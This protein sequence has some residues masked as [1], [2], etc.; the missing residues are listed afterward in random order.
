[1]GQR[2]CGKKR[3]RRTV[4]RRVEVRKDE[5]NEKELWA[6]KG[7]SEKDEKAGERRREERWIPKWPSKSKDKI[8]L[9]ARRTHSNGSR[10]AL[11]SYFANLAI[12][13]YRLP[14]FSFM[15]PSRASSD[16]ERFVSEDLRVSHFLFYLTF[17]FL[18]LLLCSSFLSILWTFFAFNNLVTYFTKI[19]HR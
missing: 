10:L 8:S 9:R 4:R 3:R 19:N 18:H 13:L 6:K 1:M 11:V 12:K 14:L 7:T 17:I 2:S 15:F 16:T 5:I